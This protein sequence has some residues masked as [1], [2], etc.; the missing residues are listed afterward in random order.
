[1]KIVSDFKDY[2]DSIGAYDREKTPLYIR[3][4]GIITNDRSTRHNFPCL[5]SNF[6]MFSVF[7][8]KVV[9]ICYRA[10]PYKYYIDGKFFGSL[11]GKAYYASVPDRNGNKLLLKKDI[12][13]MSDEGLARLIKDLDISLCK[14]Y[15]WSDDYGKE[16]VSREE[17]LKMFQ[18]PSVAEGYIPANCPIWMIYGAREH[19]QIILNPN[20]SIF[21]YQ[22]I[23]DSGTLYQ[24]LYRWLDN[25]SAPDEVSREPKGMTDKLKAETKGFDKWSFRRHK[26][27]K[28]P[29]RRKHRVL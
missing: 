16:D 28:Q 9:A 13:E 19:S 1:M 3:R 27:D 15:D 10:E 5:P 2:Y 11:P 24:E 8:Q 12:E 4:T 14:S 7:G 20:L 25:L 18:T 23:K 26:D 29:K 21:G 17:I 22:K 6:V